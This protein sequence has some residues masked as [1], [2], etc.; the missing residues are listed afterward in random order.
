MSQSSPGAP[1]VRRIR[2]E[3]RDG[4]LCT[5][6]EAFRADPQ[7]RWY[8]PDD[9][10]YDVGAPRFFGVLL[11]TRIEGGEVWVTPDLFAVSLWIPPG[12]NLLGPDVVEARYAEALAGL[13]EPAPGRIAAIDDLVDALLPREPHWYLGVLGTRPLQRHGGLASAVLAPLLAAADRGGFPVALETS[14]SGNVDFYTRRGFATLASRAVPDEGSPVVHVM[15]REPMAV[16]RR[17]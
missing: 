4:A 2:P 5:L 7:L 16:L 15:Q 12:G 3:E 1:P 10:R 17:R 14:T 9:A 13:P 11:D 6:V 8:F